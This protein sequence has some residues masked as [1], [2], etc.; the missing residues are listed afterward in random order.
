MAPNSV[1]E[2]KPVY[3]NAS[4]CSQIKNFVLVLI[5]SHIS[6][7]EDGFSRPRQNT[8]CSM[9]LVF[10]H[11]PG[12]SCCTRRTGR[13]WKRERRCQATGTPSSP[14]CSAPHL[15]EQKLF[16]VPPSPTPVGCRDW[17]APGFSTPEAALGSVSS[18]TRGAGKG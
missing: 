13:S 18:L 9:D 12:Q 10:N 17:R 8:Q 14:C 3:L 15:K 6:Y 4:L 2:Q 5:V 11:K 1:F 16:R 7:V